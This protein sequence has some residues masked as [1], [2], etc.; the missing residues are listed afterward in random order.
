MAAMAAAAAGPAAGGEGRVVLRAGFVC[1]RVSDAADQV[2]IPRGSQTDHLRKHRGAVV[3]TD[4]MAGFVPPIVRGHSESLDGRAVVE[5]LADLFRQRQATDQV[6]GSLAGGKP[7][8]EKGVS[9]H[10]VG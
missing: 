2:A 9:R 7:G 4:T 8:I 6:N 1:N 10:G 5:Q 3:A